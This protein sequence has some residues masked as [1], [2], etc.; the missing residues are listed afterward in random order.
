MTLS[1]GL[2]GALDDDGAGRPRRRRRARPAPPS[3]GSRRAATPPTS[4]R[5]T[6]SPSTS[7]SPICRGCSPRRRPTPQGRLRPWLAL[8]V[9]E[10]RPGVSIDVPAGAP[11]PQLRDRAAAPAASS[12]TSPTRG[13]GPTR[14]CSSPRARAC[15][16]ARASQS[17]PDRHVSRLLCP[18][19]LRPDARWF[20]CLVPAFDAG[21]RRG[22]G[23]A[24]L[25]DQPL[26]P[27]WTGEDS[28]T[29]PLYFHWEFCDRPGRR[30]R[31]PGPA[32][33]AVQGR[34]RQRRDADGR[35]GEDAHRR[36]RRPGRPPRRPP[37]A[38]SSRWTAR[39]APCNR[40]T[41]ASSDIPTALTTPL[42]E[43]LDAIADPSGSDPDDGA[44]G[45]P[46][47]GAW[48]ANRFHVAD[49][50]DG[51]F[52]EAQPRPAGPGRRRARRRGRAPRAGGPDDRLLGAGRRGARGQRPARRGRELSIQ[53]S[54]RL[55][56]RSIARLA[57]DRRGAH[58][59]RAAHRSRAARRGDRA[60]GDRPDLAC[61]TRSIDPALRRLLA[62]DGP[63]RPQDG[64]R[65]PRPVAAVIGT[66]FVDKLAAGSMAVDP[67]D[68]VPDRACRRRCGPIERAD[69]QVDLTPV[70][71]PAA[72]VGAGGD[73]LAR[74]RG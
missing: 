57:P 36:R 19:R 12:A 35:H 63:L 56:L 14:S 66:G 73:D 62:P 61:P 23:L 20:A 13:R 9:V 41:D 21:V 68:F 53:A 46:L 39:C 33:P 37:G 65:P 50:D 30:L 8:V 74:R 32:P 64:R 47:Y 49:L 10:D 28:I 7:T 4:S 51:W 71:L 67:T 40:T 48:A 42:G 58:V 26:G 34:R 16:A 38:R 60:G 55:H 54:I 25:A 52:A 31:E 44:V 45:P 11:L 18:R 2:G 29:L 27:A 5:T 72:H 59:R 3:S 24:P 69:R 1:G 43:L 17:D 22:L 15:E 70:G 6:S